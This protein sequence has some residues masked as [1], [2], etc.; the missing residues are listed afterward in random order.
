MS[1]VSSS[2]FFSAAFKRVKIKETL[3]AAEQKME[4]RKV[5]TRVC[6]PVSYS[7]NSARA[8][9]LFMRFKGEVG[10]C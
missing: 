2:G 1:Q 6:A 9:Y 10:L 8:L 3:P 7:E 5:K 4:L